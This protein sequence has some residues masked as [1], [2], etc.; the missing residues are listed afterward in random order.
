MQA[1]IRAHSVDGMTVLTIVCVKVRKTCHV[2]PCNI[3]SK[4]HEKNEIFL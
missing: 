2:P 1:S 3:G 4:F